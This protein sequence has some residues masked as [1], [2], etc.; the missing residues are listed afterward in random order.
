MKRLRLGIDLDGVVADFASGW[1]WFYNP[2]FGSDLQVE[3]SVSWS[4][5]ID[6]TH[7]QNMA[8]FW[9]SSAMVRAAI[10]IVVATMDYAPS[11]LRR[12]FT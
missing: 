3:D 8:E 6:L 10:T 5:L 2:E 4:G 11:R 9:K 12:R 1:M 7:F